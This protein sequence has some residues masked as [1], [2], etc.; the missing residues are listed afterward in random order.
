ML[1]GCSDADDTAG[2]LDGVIYCSEGDPISFNPQLD[3]S[4]TTSDA[5]SHQIYD[6]LI[7][8]D[9]LSGQIVP[10]LASSWLVSKDGLT[11]TFQLRRG[12][13]FHQTPYFSPN[14]TFNAD[15][16]IFSIDRWRLPDHPYH[17]VSGG[18][19]PY[20]S[21]LGLS[22]V[23]ADV[24]RINGYRV[25][26]T[27]KQP[28][29]S[30]LANLATDFAVILSAEYG[31]Q[32]QSKGTPDRIDNFPIGTG[33]FKFVEYE[34]DHHIRY[35]AHPEYWQTGTDLQQ[36]IF[37]ITPNNS[38]RLAK[39]LTGECDVLGYPSASDV[40]YLADKEGIKI[41]ES[42]SM[43]VSYW[44]SAGLAWGQ[45]RSSPTR[46]SNVDL[47]VIRGGRRCQRHRCCHASCSASADTPL[48]RA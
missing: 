13:K 15:D 25:E 20:F 12:V 45:Q 41:V 34:R 22:N 29:S 17:E 14:R 42:T 19:Y 40:G 28:D 8:F 39:L 30:F 11:Y 18:H 37:D 47:S 24:K 3:T 26:L 9:P 33:P 2:P 43:N 23:I 31:E 44:A 5:S 35:R 46:S 6:R 36:I 38:S 27:L 16:V 7:N 1:M 48:A 21:S 10:G 4:G 32:L